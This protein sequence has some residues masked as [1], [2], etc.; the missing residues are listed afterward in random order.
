[1]IG[2]LPP[3]TTKATV[4]LDLDNVNSG[5]SFGSEN[6]APLRRLAEDSDDTA[7][8]AL[9]ELRGVRGVKNS[10]NIKFRAAV[11]TRLAKW[12]D[13]TFVL[14]SQNRLTYANLTSTR[15]SPWETFVEDLDWHFTATPNH[16]DEVD[17]R[18]ERDLASRLNGPFASTCVVVISQ[19]IRMHRR[20]KKVTHDFGR[21]AHMGAVTVFDSPSNPGS[22]QQH[23]FRDGSELGRLYDFAITIVEALRNNLSDEKTS[24]E[25][26]SDAFATY[27]A[28]FTNELEVG[29]ADAVKRRRVAIGNKI[30]L[31]GTEVAD[32]VIARLN[33]P[34][35]L[36]G[37]CL[38]AG[39]LLRALERLEELPRETKIPASKI[40]NL[41]TKIFKAF[42]DRRKDLG[43]RSTTIASRPIL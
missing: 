7:A 20:V 29:N 12:C 30:L 3:P 11:L 26:R 21:V 39:T 2:E 19:D 15:T 28:G 38:E 8:A 1:M 32:Y 5:I 41:R 40:K 6:T 35:D 33:D 27:R 23:W 37:L 43:G 42:E 22:T 16:E 25:L 18:I 9:Q 24:A 17:H 13:D 4:F 10:R 14:D 34:D 36:E 31:P